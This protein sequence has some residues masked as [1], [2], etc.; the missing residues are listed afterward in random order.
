MNFLGRL[1]LRTQFVI[2]FSVLSVLI[3]LSTSFFYINEHRKSAEEL[4]DKY[5][6][7]IF[8]N[9]IPTIAN[10]IIVED[11]LKLQD[12]VN[13]IVKNDDLERAVIVDKSDRIIMDSKGEK[14]GSLYNYDKDQLKYYLEIYERDI[15]IGKITYGKM[16]IYM[17]KHKL[18]ADLNNL[19]M[20]MIIAVLLFSLLSI[21]LAYLSSRFFANPINL[22]IETIDRFKSGGI[23][24]PAKDLIAPKEIMSLY[25]YFYTFVEI[26]KEREFELKRSVKEI[27]DLK[28]YLSQLLDSIPYGIVS[29]DSEKRIVFVNSYF[30]RLFGVKGNIEGN[31]FFDIF[32]MLQD[33]EV[34]NAVEQF[35]ELSLRKKVFKGIPND[36][37]D[38]D[39]FKIYKGDD[40]YLGVTIIRVTEEVKKDAMLLHAQKL[41]A[42]GVLAGGIAHD[43]NNVLAAIKSS[44]SVMQMLN[45]PDEM[46]PIISTIEKS[47][48]RASTIVKQI[49]S[50]SRKQ[51]IKKEQVD[52]KEVLNDVLDILN[53]TVDKSVEI[54]VDLNEGVFNVFG[55]KSQLEQAILNIC[56]NGI[57]A[58]TIMR[59]DGDKGGRL[60]IKLSN[61]YDYKDQHR[62]GIVKFAKIEISDTGVG[63]PS[64][65]LEKIFDP[66]FTTKKHGE[67]TGLGLSMVYKIVKE[68]E[69]VISV[70]SEPGFGSTFVIKLP[71]HEL[72]ENRQVNCEV[73]FM[74]FAGTVMLVDDDELVLD[75]NKNLLK[76]LGFNVIDVK[77]PEE[78]DKIYELN[79]ENVNL[80]II[81]AIM[82]KVSGIEVANRL[83]SINSELKIILTSGYYNDPA[84]EEFISKQMGYFIQKPFSV[85]ELIKLLEKIGIKKSN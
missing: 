35:N 13:E 8:D 19:Y 83:K 36:F 73:T 59:K 40:I 6:N 30:K 79:R 34:K 22:L 56:I 46:K 82:P 61:I 26:I 39:I 3:I 52:L 37:Y 29:L 15:K 47:V 23:E 67:G 58:M 48:Y 50:F 80:A 53:R 84:V 76:T 43:I 49:L 44:L 38:I 64:E 63:I 32:P 10:F 4:F 74:K 18:I 60:S 70:Y 25:Y 54:S 72:A 55:D 78:A 17:N 2:L 68:H 66:F 20:N 57:H 65:D 12:L 16:I 77:N 81:D 9:S 31:L 28:N 51:E 1:N 85:I 71:I 14:I 27:E 24:E 69:G 33:D 41:D 21:F 45:C 62:R 11:Y 5:V 7:N 75:S 42:L